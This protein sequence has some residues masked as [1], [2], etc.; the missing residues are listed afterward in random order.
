MEKLTAGS[1]SLEDL[2][3]YLGAQLEGDSD[4]RINGISTLSGA[5]SDQLAFFANPKYLKELKTTQAGV[6]I[7]SQKNLLHCPCNALVMEDPYWGYA[8]VSRLFSASN[9]PA[10]VHPEA[11]IDDSANVPSSASIAPGVI[12]E[13]G[14]VLGE[15]V[16]V[17]PG[18]VLGENVQL[19]DECRLH[20]NVTLYRDVKLGSQSVIHSG[21][22]IGADGF[23]YAPYKGGWEK[24]EQ[25]GSVTIGRRVEIGANTTVDRGALDDTIIGDGVIIDNQIQIGHNVVIGEGSAIAACT[26]IAGSTKIGKHC[27]IAGA[28][29]IAGHIEITDNVHIK[30]MSQVSKS[31]T[32]AGIYAS[33][34][35]GVMDNRSW[36]KN[37][38]RFRKLN[39]LVNRVESLEKRLAKGAE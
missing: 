31:I 15:G 28:V 12:I 25:L 5:S 17:G 11:V 18:C 39:D 22:V 4:K 9:R 29:A 19:G 33:G 23:G 14:V 20:A 16:T 3:K 37:A 21:S 38:A 13:G 6:V 27:T 24:I 35:G 10:G 34:T 32:K 2:A 8:R 36:Q 30:G 26:A 1:I 7:V